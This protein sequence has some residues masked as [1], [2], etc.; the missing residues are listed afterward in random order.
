M[1]TIPE[2]S[3]EH[4]LGQQKITAKVLEA[5]TSIWGSRPPRDFDMWFAANV[6]RL[7]ELVTVGQRAAVDASAGYV[8]NAID[9]FGLDTEQLAEVEP[10]SLVD[11]ASDGRALDSLL[12]GSVITAKGYIGQNDTSGGALGAV[13]ESAWRAGLYALQLRVQTQVADA[14]RVAT[15]LNIASHTRM[16]YVRMLNPPS[17]SRCAVLAGRFYRFSAGFLRHP[18][19]DCRHVPSTED[20]ADDVLVDP[21]EYFESLSADMQDKT[22]T[23]AGAQAIRDGADM[24]QVVNARRGANGLSTAGR[25]ERRNVYGQ[26]LVTTTEG[27]TKR[28]VAGKV[29]RNRGRNPDTTPRLMPEDI[30]EIVG[31]DRDETLRM[32]QLNG[33]VL[34]RS[35]PRTGAG[36]RTG[37]VP[38]RVVDLDELLKVPLHQLPSPDL[39]RVIA[40]GRV[41]SSPPVVRPNPPVRMSTTLAEASPRQILD[42]AAGLAAHM[43]RELNQRER[44]VD[45]ATP[46]NPVAYDLPRIADDV[47]E[48]GMNVQPLEYVNR[49]VLDRGETTAMLDVLFGMNRSYESESPF[50]GVKRTYS[51]NSIDSGDGADALRIAV[52]LKHLDRADIEFDRLDL[53]RFIRD[54]GYAT[55]PTLIDDILADGLNVE[56][57]IARDILP[58]VDTAIRDRLDELIAAAKVKD[59]AVLAASNAAEAA[60]AQAQWARNIEKTGAPFKGYLTNYRG[61]NAETVSVNKLHDISYGIHSEL[62]TNRRYYASTDTVADFD[63]RAVTDEIIERRLNLVNDGAFD[64]LE[65]AEVARALTEILNK[66]RRATPDRRA[67]TL[68]VDLPA[69]K[70][71]DVKGQE[72]VDAYADFAAAA[73]EL[74]FEF[75]EMES[76]RGVFESSLKQGLNARLITDPDVP[77][78]IKNAAK[79]RF[80]R[81]A[82]EDD[83]DDGYEVMP[84]APR[85]GSPGGIPVARE[86][87]VFSSAE[88]VVPEI[89]DRIKF[90]QRLQFENDFL[91]VPFQARQ[92][93]GDRGV[94]V[95]ASQRV[96]QGPFASLFD[97]VTSADGRALDEISFYQNQIKAVVISTDAQHGSVNVVA[98]EIGHALDSNALLDNPI[99]VRWQEQGNPNLPA[100]IVAKVQEPT[101]YLIDRFID[102]PYVRWA[103]KEF[104]E[105]TPGVD[106]YYRTGSEGTSVSGREEWIAEG[107]ASLVQ[108]N[109]AQ[110]AAISGGSREAMDILA[111]TFRRMGVLP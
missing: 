99:E 110:L 21:T 68:D 73:S 83:L 48:A 28:G 37:L 15:G 42:T 7:V 59:D 85:S 70:P 92:I 4:Y 89:D 101:D 49:P 30:Y 74:D 81:I 86:P 29:I 61:T 12:Y 9:E 78:E 67:R 1:L 75:E 47:L 13:T 103:H 100:S 58:D 23:V 43:R 91:A 87:A 52:A 88:P 51:A 5:A 40:S 82:R 31:G 94:R 62:D 95:V 90:M 96:S 97:G 25:I 79:E 53:S 46:L 16:G 26:Q 11:I 14:S 104:I 20:I 72:F 22:F 35:G 108:G 66:H 109:A 54:P 38:R 34:D 93:L 65:E 24:S 69:R 84:S 106:P 18:G 36:S 64:N 80:W 105:S 63:I 76:M 57:L 111:W 71:K 3:A 33:Y 41:M 17:C 77:A 98:H 55:A 10:S 8:D 50:S 39:D 2:S 19:C 27:T 32:L 102:D 107:Y 44:P 60:A 45:R 56:H 6:D